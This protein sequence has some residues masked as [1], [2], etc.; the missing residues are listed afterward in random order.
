MALGLTQP[1]EERAPGVTSSVRQ[2][3]HMADNAAN[4]MCH[5]SRNS[6][7]FNLL[8]HSWSIQACQGIAV[9]LPYSN[10]SDTCPCINRSA[11]M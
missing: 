11:G 8:E 4:F 9:P 6:G 3:V 10:N 5:L 2:P 1:L 7:G